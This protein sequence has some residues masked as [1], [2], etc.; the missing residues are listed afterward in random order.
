MPNS[1]LGVTVDAFGL[2]LFGPTI[3]LE[4]GEQ[5]SLRLLY[6][7]LS[8]GAVSH[9]ALAPEDGDSLDGGLSFGVGYRKY[10]DREYA[11]RGLYWGVDLEYMVIETS[12]SESGSS[13][14][15]TSDVLTSL[16]HFGY[17][18]VSEDMLIGDLFGVGLWLAYAVPLESSQTFSDNTDWP[19]SY[20][21]LDNESRVY[22]G[23]SMELG[24]MF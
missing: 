1:D 15:T 17:R 14:S 16:L 5:A 10:N 21:E 9:V 3:S 4:M 6:R 8:M 22:G 13:F 12:Y 7:G 19:E 18:W 20:T 23:I 11:R 24:W 2:L